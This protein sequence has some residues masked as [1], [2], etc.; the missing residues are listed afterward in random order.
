MKLTL[1]FKELENFFM[2]LEEL[3]VKEMKEDGKKLMEA[4]RWGEEM[5]MKKT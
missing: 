4:G 3:H 5:R 2:E 1:V